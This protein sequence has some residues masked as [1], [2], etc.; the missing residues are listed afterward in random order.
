MWFDM[1][2]SIRW[3]LKLLCLLCS[4][5]LL[6]PPPSSG[7]LNDPVSSLLFQNNFL[8]V[9]LLN[10]VVFQIFGRPQWLTVAGRSQ[11]YVAKVPS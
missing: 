3:C 1:V 10:F 4:F 5:V 2:M 6:Q 7:S 8:G 11:T 9:S